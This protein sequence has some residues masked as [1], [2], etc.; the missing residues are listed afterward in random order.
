MRIGAVGAE[1][2]FLQPDVGA[3]EER[4]KSSGPYKAFVYQEVFRTKS[5]GE[6]YLYVNDAVLGI[7]KY[8][9]W[10]YDRRSLNKG[11]TR[12]LIERRER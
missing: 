12:V 2:E 6:I 4:M 8:F 3:I 9:S 10:F 1:E 11:R 7:Q 5:S